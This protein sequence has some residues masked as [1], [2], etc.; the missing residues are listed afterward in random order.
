VTGCT[1]N[2][3]NVHLV[4]ID[5]RDQFTGDYLCMATYF[6]FCPV[7]DTMFWCTD[8]VS[9]DA[10]INISKYGDSSLLVFR[11]GGAY[12]DYSFIGQYLR[13]NYFEC[14]ECNGPPD[15]ARFFGTDSV[16]VRRKAGVTNEYNYY[17]KKL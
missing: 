11:E 10:I 16:R 12:S 14:L 9:Y 13:E 2:T 3:D 4:P 17:G 8:T 1:K 5:F 6:Y 7:G 15:F